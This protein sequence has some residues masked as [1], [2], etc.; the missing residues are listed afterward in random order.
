[1]WYFF[2][3]SGNWQEGDKKRLVIGGIVVDNYKNLK[4]IND[5]IETFKF[6]RNLK[7][8]HANEMNKVDKELALRLI[9]NLL[10]ENRFKALLYVIDP[11]VLLK[12]QKESD[13]VYADIASDLMVEIAFGDNEIKVE[14]DMKFHYAYPIQIIENIENNVI[15]Y[16]FNQMKR[17]FYLNENSVGR[18]KERIKR[19]ILNNKRNIPNFQEI[20]YRLGNRRFLY[21]YL[22]EEFRL[23][24]EKGAIIREKFKDKVITKLKEKYKLLALNKE[25]VINIEYKGKHNQS[26][27]VQIIDFLTYIV[28]FHGKNPSYFS[29][30]IVEDIYKF[31]TIR[32]RNA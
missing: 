12:T 30:Q 2:D 26:G 32:E 17:N 3:E 6:E 15:S 22:W 23:K 8:L 7:Y 5:K 28:R 13:E 24:I 10:Q 4:F 9:L 20:L 27:G 11:K 16:E 21:N 1:M 19:I 18:Q 25:P 14:Y 31:I 29:P